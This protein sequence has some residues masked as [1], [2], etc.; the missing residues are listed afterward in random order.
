MI[1]EAFG[2]GQGWLSARTPTPKAPPMHP[3]TIIVLN[4]LRW[5][6]GEEY[7]KMVIRSYSSM[8]SNYD[9]GAM[10]GLKST[11]NRI[12]KLLAAAGPDAPIAFEFAI[13]DAG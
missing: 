1:D 5:E 10:V 4:T 8:H 2:L 13:M 9:H 6:I 3:D 7:Q 12:D 11:L